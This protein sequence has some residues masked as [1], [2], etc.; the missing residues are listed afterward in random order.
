MKIKLTLLTRNIAI[1]LLIGFFYLAVIGEV[2]A[3]P[4]SSRIVRASVTSTGKEGKYASDS[5]VL[6]GN[7]RYVA[8]WSLSNLITGKGGPKGGVYVR[9]LKKGVTSRIPIGI[10]GANYFKIPSISDNGRFVFFES[11]ASNLV[12]GDT[13]GSFD[14]FVYDRKTGKIQLVSV[15]SNGEQGNTD[16]SGLF[17][18]ISANGRYVV[19]SSIASNLVPNDNNE[20][21]DLFVRDLKLGTTQRVSVKSNGEGCT[22]GGLSIVGRS[23]SADGSVVA[24]S[25][26]CRDLVPNDN[27]NGYDIFVHDLK[28]GLTT[29]VSVGS[30]GAEGND[31]SEFPDISANGRFIV[32]SSLANNLVDGDNNNVADVFV[33]DLKTGETKIV[34]LDSDERQGNEESFLP[35]ISRDG[36]YV[37]FQSDASNLVSDDTNG[38]RDVFVRDIKLGVTKRVSVND[39]GEESNGIKTRNW[40][41][42]ISAD[43]KYVAF[44]SDASNLVEGDNNAID[45]I[46]VVRVR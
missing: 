44:S 28:T 30:N 39:Q 2:N 27:N 26:A 17:N 42:T 29:R 22:D 8:F 34:S 1:H 31:G 18:S 21:G 13:N 4:L 9:D 24:F 16:S 46:F 35:S 3:T 33:H 25:S 15:N 7:G 10:E 32:F 6:S 36:R 5:P 23:I 43:G 45:D 19:F 40:F 11:S 41:S 38:N 14:V 37:A 12:A 20:D